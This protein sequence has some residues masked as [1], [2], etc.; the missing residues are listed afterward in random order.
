MSLRVPWDKQ[1]TAL[2][3]DAYM[4]VKNK[5]LSNREAVKEVSAILR[6]RAIKAGKKI[7]NVF[8]NVNGITMQMKLVGGLIDNSPSSLH[9]YSKIFNEMVTLYKN[10]LVEFHKILI[11]A[12]SE[13]AMQVKAGNVIIADSSNTE[14]ASWNFAH[15]SIDFINIIP[16]AIYYFGDLQRALGWVEAFLHIVRAMQ[17][18]YPS[19][20]RGM[21]GYSFVDLGKVV[22]TS[23]SGIDSL[24]K[25]VELNNRIYL[26][27]NLS[28]NEMVLIIRILMDRCN[29]DYNNV[30]ICYK[31]FNSIGVVAEGSQGY[32][33]TN[34][35]I[36]ATNDCIVLE[37]KERYTKILGDK[38]ADGFRPEKTIDRNRFRMYYND[39]F[40]E[41]LNEDDDSLV[42]TLM[43]VGT[44]RDERIFV[45]DE[46]AQRSLIEEI[47][48]TIV[49]TF[50]K[51]A[52]CICLKCLFVRFQQQLAEVLHIYSIS[53][54]E[55]VLFSSKKRNYLKKYN[56]LFE[57]NK[58]PSLAGDV[59]EYMEKSHLPV[60]YS[61]IE[62][63][64]W[65]IP[66]DK[67]K[68][69]LVNTS[70][71]VNVAKETYLYAP[72]LPVS[73]SDIQQIAE[74]INN[75]LLQ[76]SY[77][78]DVELRQILEEHCPSVLMNTTGYPIWGLRNALSYLLR[79]R[80]SFRGSII[81]N[82]NEEISMVDVFSTFC[83]SSER[84]T[85]DELKQFA[86]ELD[87]V[88]YWESVYSEMVRVN[89]NEFIRKDQIHFD[90]KKIDLILDNL[91]SEAY[92]PIKKINLFLHFPVI[93]VRWNNFVLESY[94]A[95]YSEKFKLLHV[96]YAAS[97]C[98]GAMVRQDAGISDYRTLIIDV[99]S[100]NTTWETKKDALQLLVDL[101]YQ[102]KKSYRNI[103]EV[104]REAKA[105]WKTHQN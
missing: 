23:I 9:S 19:I 91:I 84:I 8:R 14:I 1:E 6:Y 92:T 78:S 33:C 17:D 62:N 37:V 7:D 101:G 3:I 22:L 99:L 90:I 44:S 66:L 61:E 96:G 38:F 68:S 28:P 65:Y 26:E 88:I 36:S 39:M 49:E 74:L 51:G 100:K 21:V 60:T 35:D 27:T 41:E 10:N 59:I 69:T 56:Y 2:L 76:R 80:F 5:E 42:C 47:N 87:T 31:E 54:F 98:C 81:S 13:C 102:K 103:E 20:I 89:Q 53:S 82:K 18:D 71:I 75:A 45:K 50:R 12:K 4:R 24:S 104:M 57:Y 93:D 105:K 40:G 58:E 70:G 79:E 72:N 67:I 86:S 30:E 43:K 52:S 77:I 25:P 64:L 95:K 97:D 83:Q 46:T 29:V 63:A 85:V 16:T 73:Q 55:K 32:E 11:K 15:D 48:E 34:S 94:V